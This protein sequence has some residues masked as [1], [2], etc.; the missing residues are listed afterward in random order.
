MAKSL[1]LH[2]CCGPCS[3]SVVSYLRQEYFD[4]TVFFFNPNIH[5][6]S[7]YRQR[8]AAQHAFCAKTKTELIIYGDYGFNVFMAYLDGMEGVS[9]ILSAGETTPV[10]QS[11]RCAMCYT[12][13][14]DEV[15][16]FAQ[17]NSYPFF[18]TT[19]LYSIYQNHDLI[20]AIGEQKARQYNLEFVYHDFRQFW[21]EGKALSAQMD[22]YRQKYC[23]CI[24]SIHEAQQARLSRK[25]KAAGKT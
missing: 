25:K 18:S 22:L 21:D 2:S 23:G 7:E 9:P 20:R 1:L 16:R 10:S 19:L 4:P 14:L 6:E 13:R 12:Q 15:A 11:N 24:Y 17:R 3:T 5:P 8:L